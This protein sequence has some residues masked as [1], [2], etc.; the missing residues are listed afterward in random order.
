M[1]ALNYHHLRYFW[2]IAHERNLTRAAQRLHVSQ[3][4]LSIQLRQLEERLGQKLFERSGRRLVLTEAGR[5]AL[6]YADTIFRAGD[7]LVGLLQ[8]RG[9]AGRQPLRI[10]AVAT[11]SRNFQ[12]ALL[13]PLIDR[14]DIELVLHS[15]SLRDLLAQLDAHTLDLV[16]AN[17]DVPR[18][19]GRPWHS[20]LIAQQPVSLVGKPQASRRRFRFPDDLHDAP[21]VLPGSASS[22]RASFDL[23][24]DEAGIRPKIVAE[25]DDMAMLRL[26]ARESDALTLLPPVV[27][28]DELRAR[29]LVERC[30][31][32]Q[33]TE[34]FFAISPS[35][36]YPN[37]LV[38]ELLATR[39]GLPPPPAGTR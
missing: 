5:I 18:D 13:R 24:M 3:S 9:A 10:G 35:R 6:D 34:S 33:I 21:V 1:P 29:L 25:V 38:R 19:A 8:G 4:A 23:V 27:V 17:V 30:R 32:P 11:L 36:R 37:P 20:Y 12:F 2:A 39:G 31:I 14:P 7:E 28:H 26:I 16:L 15:G 22:L